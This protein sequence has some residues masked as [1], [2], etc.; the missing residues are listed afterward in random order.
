MKIVE[1][2]KSSM[3]I[4]DKKESLFMIQ[5]WM[6][7][8]LKMRTTGYPQKRRPQPSLSGRVP[9][10]GW[11]PYDGLTM[12]LRTSASVACSLLPL[13]LLLPNTARCSRETP[14]SGLLLLGVRPPTFWFS[15]LIALKAAKR[16]SLDEFPFA[17]SKSL[18]RCP[19]RGGRAERAGGGG[20]VKTGL[21]RS[22]SS[23]ERRSIRH[24]GQEPATLSS[25]GSIQSM[26]NEW[27]HGNTRT[28]WPSSKSSKQTKHRVSFGPGTVV[29]DCGSSAVIVYDGGSCDD[30]GVNVSV[31]API[32]PPTECGGGEGVPWISPSG[33]VFSSMVEPLALDRAP[34]PIFFGA[35][36]NG[37]A[38]NLTIGRVSRAALAIPRARDRLSRGP[39]WSGGVLNPLSCRMHA[40]TPQKQHTHMSRHAIVG[41]TT[42][43]AIAS[44][45]FQRRSSDSESPCQYS[46][47]KYPS[48]PSGIQPNCTMV[49]FVLLT[50]GRKYDS[51]APPRWSTVKINGG[52]IGCIHSG[53]NLKSRT[54]QSPSSVYNMMAFA[55]V[56]IAFIKISL[57]SG[58]S[59]LMS[60]MDES[61]IGGFG[62]SS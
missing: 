60:K 37:L 54:Q 30:G 46:S 50:R 8:P 62:P 4:E 14:N 51:S 23:G 49:P 1:T 26:W 35:A 6:Y 59:Q 7:E 3:N 57:R 48:S 15:S 5:P 19:G 10:S 21:S 18:W 25:H 40:L 12:T 47:S 42:N 20:R 61:F 38:P 56:A 22:W 39:G 33:S 44:G 13:L 27:E 32:A 34:G 52:L 29:E 58:P 11:M 43:M 36:S 31:V 2:K 24:N 28:S 41:T 55:P 16:S 45:P 17:T 9:L 53:S